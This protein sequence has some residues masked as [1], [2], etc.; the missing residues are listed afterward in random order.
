M[1]GDFWRGSKCVGHSFKHSDR[2]GL[3]TRHG[4]LLLCRVYN[5]C[6]TLWGFETVFVLSWCQEEITFFLASR[7]ILCNYIGMG[8]G[9]IQGL[10][11]LLGQ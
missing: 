11:G 4:C 7:T 8:D 2:A 6:Y 5:V 3:H 10:L 1:C 9:N